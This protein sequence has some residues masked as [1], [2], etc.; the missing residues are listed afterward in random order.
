M[1]ARKVR[2]ILDLDAT[3]SIEKGHCEKTHGPKELRYLHRS[4]FRLFLREPEERG[5]LS[6][7]LSGKG[8]GKVISLSLSL[9]R[10]MGQGLLMER[11]WLSGDRS[12]IAKRRE[13]GMPP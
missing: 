1:Q 8:K 10:G 5:A 11:N 9:G 2:P 7:T 13:P 4:V 6:L 3:T 12:Q